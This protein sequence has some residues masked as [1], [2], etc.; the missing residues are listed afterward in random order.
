MKDNA[1]YYFFILFLL[2]VDQV[3]KTIITT[4]FNI[5]ESRVVIAGFFNLTYIRNRG[6]IFGFFSSTQSFFVYAL[7]TLASLAAL[8]LVVYYFYKT[9]SS[10]RFLKISL[11]LII[12]GA[13]GNL[14]DRLFRGS[15]VDFLDF[16]VKDWHW[17]FFNVA[18]S[19]ITVGAILLLYIFFFKKGDKCFPSS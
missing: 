12:A 8:G 19:C 2:L 7:L 17:P 14:T 6:A 18:D 3:T 1:F 15:V 10:E 13:L 11:S 16:Y 9:P 5:Y 4:T